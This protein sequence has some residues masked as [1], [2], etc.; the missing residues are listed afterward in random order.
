M[1]HTES[2]SATGE[3]DGAWAPGYEDVVVVVVLLLLRDDRDLAGGS[4]RDIRSRVTFPVI[5]DSR[6]RSSPG[7]GGNGYICRLFVSL[8]LARARG[9]D[10]YLLLCVS[11]ASAAAIII[12]TSIMIRRYCHYIVIGE[13][14]RLR[15][16]SCTKEKK[17]IRHFSGVYNQRAESV[18]VAPNH[19]TY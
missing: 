6:H 4:R 15:V 1:S 14:P 7:L 10:G 18:V 8:S 19:S 3:S 16:S 5:N 17:D 9:T 11:V 13:A 12:I 2:R